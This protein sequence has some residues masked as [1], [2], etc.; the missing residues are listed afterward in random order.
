VRD[1]ASRFAEST[2]ADAVRRRPRR[3]L[4]AIA[5]VPVLLLAALG[6]GVSPTSAAYLHSST[7]SASFGPDGTSSSFFPSNYPIGFARDGLRVSEAANR[8]ETL[9]EEVFEPKPEAAIGGF[10]L[11]N[12]F[13]PLT[14][15]FPLTLPGSFGFSEKVGFA[16]DNSA[17]PSDG[18]IYYFIGERLYG[19]DSA[20]VPLAGFPADLPE[21]F[22]PCGAAVDAHGHIWIYDQDSEAVREFSASGEPLA[23]SAKL[24]PNWR[25]GCDLAFDQTN[26]DLYVGARKNESNGAGTVLRFV[27]ADGYSTSSAIELDPIHHGNIPALAFDS[28]HKELYVARYQGPEEQIDVYNPDGE[29]IDT[30]EPGGA[31]SSLAVD[32]GTG[33]LYGLSGGQIFELQ[34]SAIIPD[35]SAEEAVGT[36]IRAHVDPLSA[37]DVTSCQFEYGP[38]TSYGNAP[39]PCDQ[40]PPLSEPTT[41]TATLPSPTKE[42]PYFYRARATNANGT[43]VSAGRRFIPHFV[44]DLKTE[45]ADNL[46]K[47]SATLNASYTGNGLD[48]H[49]YFQWGPTTEYGNV[50]VTPPGVDAG[51]GIGAQTVGANLSGL[52]QG[53]TYHYRVIASNSEG[54]SIAQDR[55]FSSLDAVTGLSASATNITGAT[56]TLNGFWTGDGTDTHYYFEWGF[57]PQYGHVSSTPPGED[58][59]PVTGPQHVTFDLPEV[60]ATAAYHYRFVASNPSGT[61]IGPDMKFKTP[62]LPLVGYFPVLKLTTTSAELTGKVNPQKTGSTT[63]HFDYGLTSSYGSSTTESAS[64][65]SDET[66]HPASAEIAGLSPGTTYHYRL[67]ATSVGGSAFG[68][69]RTVI[70]VPN[71]PAIAGTSASDV[72]GF[73]ASL[74]AQIKPGFGPTVVLFQYGVGIPYTASTVPSSPLPAD[75]TEHPVGVALSGLAPG[76]TYHYRAVAINFAGSAYGEDQTFE[77]A[78]LPQVLAGSATAVTRTT[79]T[80]TA[81]VTPG[82]AQ[83]KVHFEYGTDSSYG[84]SAPDVV[85]DSDNA[86]HS[87]SATVSG[88]AP[89]TTYHYRVVATN[90]VG[91]AVGTDQSFTTAKD[92]SEDTSPP[93]CSKNRVRRHGK[94]VK[95]HGKHTK[96]HHHRR[97]N[98]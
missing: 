18:N 1:A 17:F 86:L 98:G 28:Q 83:T 11:S 46:T 57:T 66:F 61:T 45:S 95:K 8:L 75:D 85:L 59:G 58:A 25:E 36:T 19:F 76:T 31:T 78:S 88:L 4:L 73:T 43:Y 97:R 20:G 63:Y 5:I 37:G 55:T 87:M 53:K 50:T 38:T 21:P 70:T 79:A 26:D 24:L 81:S 10:D 54:T 52:T 3:T 13:T 56:A 49:Y 68:P 89:G 71:S 77:T 82:G 39:L 69:D 12:P 9:R 23:G 32:E 34:P 64:V 35:V 51:M 91:G 93:K 72:T 60:L 48:T 16:V 92:T 14:G 67:V 90:S 84:S 94:C 30:I 6:L 33:A 40:S 42:V 80:L 2:H 96:K 62:K 41:V 74:N 15:N 47:T 29:L 44:E 22:N 7:P 65:G 27:A